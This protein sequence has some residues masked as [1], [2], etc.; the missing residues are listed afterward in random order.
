MVERIK[1]TGEIVIGIAI[2][3]FVAAGVVHGFDHAF[4]FEVILAI[5]A[6]S[7]VF[8]GLH[9]LTPRRLIEGREKATRLGQVYNLKPADAVFMAAALFAFGLAIYALGM[10]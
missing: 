2:A 8:F 5:L 3:I 9:L 6:F 4:R 7:I 10:I 1:N